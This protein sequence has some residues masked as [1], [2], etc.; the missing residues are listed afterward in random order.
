MTAV[1]CCF[2]IAA[3]SWDQ[4]CMLFLWTFLLTEQP[5]H[6]LGSLKNIHQNKSHSEKLLA[7]ISFLYLISNKILCTHSVNNNP[8]RSEPA[9]QCAIGCPCPGTTSNLIGRHTFCSHCGQ[10]RITGSVIM[11]MLEIFW[12][13]MVIHAQH[14]FKFSR[15][16]TFFLIYFVWFLII[17]EMLFLGKRKKRSTHIKCFY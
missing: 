8:E 9:L 7:G 4:S 17:K 1:V 10:E 13:Q 12:I 6:K 2:W 3:Q 14:I 15:V 16:F 5:S 11:G